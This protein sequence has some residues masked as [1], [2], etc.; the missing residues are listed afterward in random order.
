MTRELRNCWPCPCIP[1]ERPLPPPPKILCKLPV[2]AG[3][4]A[5]GK[6]DAEDRDNGED[7]DDDEGD[8]LEGDD[9]DED[10]IRV[11]VDVKLE[12]VI[13]LPTTS[14]HFTSADSS[15]GAHD[16]NEDATPHMDA[17]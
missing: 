8:G 17:S 12:E 3:G 2:R 11:D 14:L 9:E 7:V 5:L 16:T 13:T 10:D 1:L 6:E 4:A 15:C